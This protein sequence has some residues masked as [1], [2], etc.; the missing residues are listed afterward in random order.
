VQ[1]FHSLVTLRR[2]EIASERLEVIDE[3]R[4]KHLP[5]FSIS[6][7]RLRDLSESI[8]EDRVGAVVRREVLEPE[9]LCVRPQ[10]PPKPVTFPIAGLA[11]LSHPTRRAEL[12][13]ADALR[14]D[15]CAR[16]TLTNRIRSCGAW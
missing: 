2:T 13:Q 14:L 12:P 3:S 10:S 7:R 11:S 16:P 8:C 4:A 15:T 6:E 1:L 9:L 5:T